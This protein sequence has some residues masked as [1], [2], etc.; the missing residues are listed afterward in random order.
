MYWGIAF[1]L[2]LT[3]FLIAR[4]NIFNRVVAGFSSRDARPSW[5]PHKW[6][7]PFL[8][9]LL[10]WVFYLSAVAFLSF[11]KTIDLHFTKTIELHLGV[12]AVATLPLIF[13]SSGLASAVAWVSFIRQ[14]PDL[15][16]YYKMKKY[17]ESK[18]HENE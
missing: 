16:E 12:I 11:T 15:Y 3:G 2:W 17:F 1:F 8:C 4:F 6:F 14:H 10:S 9:R 5:L 13:I 18:F 7:V